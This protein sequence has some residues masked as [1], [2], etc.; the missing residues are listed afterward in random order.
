MYNQYVHSK[1][2]KRI[3][4]I[5]CTISSLSLHNT[6]DPLME[7][8]T[9]ERPPIS[10]DPFVSNH[11]F[12]SL[13]RTLGDGLKIHSPPALYYYF[14]EVEI[15]LCTPIPLC[16]P[17]S[18]HSGSASWD[19]CGSV[20]WQVACELIFLIGSHSMPG[21]QSQPTPTLW[22]SRGYAC[23]DVNCRLHFWQNDQG[24]LRSATVVTQ[25]GTDIE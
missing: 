14:L 9:N 24:L 5:S 1:V 4:Y 16:R 6:A 23:L 2:K 12:S 11:S 8:H 10:S 20:P 17:G 18:V 13:S 25:G 22:G 15:S 3:K 19:D 7:D 21:Q